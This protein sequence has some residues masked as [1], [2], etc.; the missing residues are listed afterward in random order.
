MFRNTSR[1]HERVRV[2]AREDPRRRRGHRETVVVRRRERGSTVS[3][4]DEGAETAADRVPGGWVD[5]RGL[6]ANRSAFEAIDCLE[7]GVSGG[8][9]RSHYVRN[10]ALRQLEIM[11]ERKMNE[12]EALKETEAGG[13]RSGAIRGG[14]RG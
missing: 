14:Q 12:R 3:S 6:Y 7:D 1:V 13:T 11:R 10:F 5:Q 9:T 4:T 2:R 8:R